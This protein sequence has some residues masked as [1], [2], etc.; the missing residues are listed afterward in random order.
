MTILGKI[1]VIVNF[2]FSL[3]AAGLIMAVYASSTNWHSYATKLEQ[4][5]K[6][7]Q[8][9]AQAYKEEKDRHRDE[10]GK[11]VADAA[12]ANKVLAKERD[13]ARAERERVTK[14]F[15]SEVQA[16]KILDANRD[17]LTAELQRRKNEIDQLNNLL[18]ASDKK[19]L[20]IEK[21]KKDLRD[22]AVGAELAAKSEHDRN[23]NLLAQYEAQV[24]EIEKLRS[25]GVAGPGGSKNPPPEEVEGQ[26]AAL[27]PQSG[28]L[29]ISIGSDAGL[30]RGNTLEVYR[31]KPEA[32]YLG[33]VRI[34]DVRPHEA[35][36][37]PVPGVARGQIQVGDKVASSIS[38][39]R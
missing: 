30:S 8:D 6:I 7:A 1:L 26:V 35:V 36:A 2:A 9:N 33:T 4:Q 32:R 31:T 21:E 13:D 17:S 28:Y 37:K 10:L 12:A 15:D 18:T 39:R 23:M 27:D 16:R 11:E 38:L 5:I 22:R 24:K 20:E 3:I 19:R 29:T 14:Q 34:L 25:V